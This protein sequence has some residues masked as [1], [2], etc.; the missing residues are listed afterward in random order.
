MDTKYWLMLCSLGTALISGCVAK[1]IQITETPK[2][3]P[4]IQS[5]ESIWDGIFTEKQVVRGEFTYQKSCAECHM[6]DLSGHEMASP[7][8]GAVFTFRWRNK[9]IAA[10]FESI[11]TTMPQTAPGSLGDQEYLDIIAFLLDENGYPKG[12][13]QLNYD[14]GKLSRYKIERP[15]K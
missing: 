4:F 15:K 6:H 2:P 3:P 8:V 10:L 1:T 12:L 9:S 7:L 14:L 5:V 11:R 13:R